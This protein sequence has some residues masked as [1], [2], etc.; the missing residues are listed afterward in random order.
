MLI[1]FRNLLPKEEK[2]TKFCTTFIGD[3]LVD[4]FKLRLSFHNLDKVRKNLS[5]YLKVEVMTSQRGCMKPLSAQQVDMGR[6]R[7]LL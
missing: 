4:V 6:G 5:L 3:Q 1:E 7:A 2:R